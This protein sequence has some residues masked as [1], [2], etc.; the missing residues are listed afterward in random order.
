MTRLCA[1][2]AQTLAEYG[3][4][5][6]V[7][8]SSR[9]CYGGTYVIYGRFTHHGTVSIINEILTTL[10][11]DKIYVSVPSVPHWTLSSGVSDW[12]GCPSTSK[13]TSNVNDSSAYKTVAE[14]SKTT[15][16]RGIQVVVKSTISEH[17]KK[18]SFVSTVSPKQRGW[19]LTYIQCLY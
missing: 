4:T 17:V 8:T 2:K 1:N 3:A 12:V 16:E 5:F 7:L 14:E 13:A 19:Y 18:S 10:Y 9:N 11:L 15:R 6:L